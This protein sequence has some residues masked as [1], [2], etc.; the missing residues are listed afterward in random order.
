VER[1]SNVGKLAATT[2]EHPF[3][4]THTLKNTPE[5]N[6]S[7]YNVQCIEGAECNRYT[8]QNWRG[9]NLAVRPECWHVEDLGSNPRQGVGGGPP[10]GRDGLMC[11]YNEKCLSYSNFRFRH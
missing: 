1:S 10:F 4:Q 2:E 6:L 5:A 9:F 3:L 8:T 11:N 7:S